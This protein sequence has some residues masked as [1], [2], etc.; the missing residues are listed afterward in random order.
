MAVKLRASSVAE[1]VIALTIIAICFTI[2]SQVFVRANR[3]TILFREVEEQTEFQSM[4]L[5]ALIADTLPV[6]KDW[7]GEFGT[8]EETLTRK[9]S[10]SFREYKLST[11]QRTTW[12]Q[13][14]FSGR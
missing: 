6:Q 8:I 4:M 14:F 11:N 9:D 5:D 12:Q 13:E 1:V 10:V 2:A 3:S 7:K